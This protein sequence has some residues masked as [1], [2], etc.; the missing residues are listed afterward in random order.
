MFVIHHNPACGTSRRV[1]GDLQAT[2][3]P[4]EVI[5]YLETGWTRAQLLGLFAAA[6]L[7]P[8]EALRRNDPLVA[9]LGL[10]DAGDE[11]VLAAMVAHPG[12]VERP[13]VCTPL[14][15]RLCRPAERLQEI[16]PAP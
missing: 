13:F 8:H 5:R 10:A 16:L 1:L 4:V 6:G 3:A 11:A 14:G 15:V 7:T 12:L 9:E 2:G